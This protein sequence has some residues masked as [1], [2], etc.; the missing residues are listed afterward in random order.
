MKKQLIIALVLLL[1]LST[2]YTQENFNFN[3]KFN[4]KEIEIDN[5]YIEDEIEI[6]KKLSFLYKTNFLFLDKKRMKTKLKEFEFIDSFEVK[7]IYPNKIII[8]ITEKKPI[9]VIQNKTEKKYFTSNGET[10]NYLNLKEFEQLPIVFG[11][12]K[13]FKLFYNELKLKN[14]PINEI[15]TF[16]LFESNRWDLITKKNQIIKLPKNNYFESLEN[17]KKLKD[18]ASFEK[19]KTFDYRINNQ[20]ILK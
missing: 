2:Y 3:V 8:K 17:F 15:K 16:Y 5:N 9:A 12:R 7:T 18:Q 4:I 19:Y 11:D 14:F 6:K 13:S 10:I 20:L 1:L